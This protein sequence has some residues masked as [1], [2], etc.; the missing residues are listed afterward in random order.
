MTDLNHFLKQFSHRLKLVDCC[1][2][3]QRT[4]WSALLLSISFQMTG[5][6][7]PIRYLWLWTMI[8]I[9]IWIGIV[10]GYIYI[11][12]TS[13]SKIARRVDNEL[14]LQER[15]STSIF[16][17]TEYQEFSSPAFRF[18]Q[19][20]VLAQQNDA[21]SLAQSIQPNRS[22]PL[23]V[24]SRPMVI[25]GILAFVLIILFVVPNSM[26]A[27]LN[28][29][30]A[31]KSTAQEQV[32]RIENLQ[33][34]IA[35][36]GDLSEAEKQELIRELAELS[37]ALQDNRGDI[38]DALA[39]LSKVERDLKARLNPESAEQQA[40]LQSLADQLTALSGMES[41]PDQ[42]LTEA[43][44]EALKQL[45]EQMKEMSEEQRQE[46]AKELAQMSAQ[47][48]QSYNEGIAQALSEMAN[49]LQNGNLEDAVQASQDLQGELDQADTQLAE[50]GAINQALAQ[51]QSSQQALSQ[52]SGQTSQSEGTN[53]SLGETTGVGLA[54]V[55]GQGQPGGSGTKADSLPPDTGQ[56]GLNPPQGNVPQTTEGQLNEQVYVPWQQSNASGEELFIPGQDLGQGENQSTEGESNLPATSNPLLVPYSQ[57][58][59][60]Y[61]TAAYQAIQQNYIPSYLLDYIRLYFSQLEPEE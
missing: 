3:A 6:F 31:I 25:A 20:M 23:R 59:S 61:L 56:G 33:Q 12:P 9:F 51:I 26:N 37:I 1:L 43:T 57:V 41:D 7:L 39:D 35:A 34:E 50:Q 32:S 5:R 58:Y 28:Q 46:L 45:T 36:N 38:E 53:Q 18:P 2:L 24:V 19:D 8:L 11:K 10:I 4:F 14:N 27:V 21:L 42:E 54:P 16:L 55:P 49:A 17:Q 29:R 40:N 15:L 48:S 60:N 47:A 52:A 13:L 30:D 22:F 44:N